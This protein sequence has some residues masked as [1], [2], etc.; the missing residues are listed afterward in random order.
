MGTPPRTSPPSQLSLN[1]QVSRQGSNCKRPTLRTSLTKLLANIMSNPTKTWHNGANLPASMYQ[2]LTV[3]PA[4]HSQAKRQATGSSVLEEGAIEEHGRTYHHYKAD[5]YMLPNDGDEQNR[6]DL[7]HKVISILMD[8]QLHWAPLQE[9]RNALDLGTGTG[10]WAI[11]FARKY[12]NCHVTA[13]DLSTIQPKDV[14]HNVEFVR[15]DAEDYWTIPSNFDYIHSRLFCS[16]INDYRAVLEKAY[17]H[18]QPGGWI[19][20]HEFP[21]WAETFFGGHDNSANEEISK[22]IVQ[23]LQ[24]GGKDPF[25]YQKIPLLLQ[26]VGFVDIEENVQPIPIGDWP[27][28]PKYKLAGGWN[29]MNALHGLDST[30]K[31]LVATGRS[32]EQAQLLIQRA[33]DEVRSNTM[34][35]FGPFHVIIGRKPVQ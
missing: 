4:L 22:S 17:S 23:I 2:P 5:S 33:Q 10:I 26:Q 19:E 16:F 1:S 28:D 34:Y 8:D 29:A 24:A 20:L 15:E 9:P 3:D 31:M 21:L 7:Q 32:E 30:V 18:L 25:V 14:A 6:L 27:E 11:H 12:P 35:G 13:T